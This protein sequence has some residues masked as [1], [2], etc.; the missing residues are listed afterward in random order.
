MGREGSQVLKPKLQSINDDQ[1]VT[2][3]SKQMT[4]TKL[5]E[6]PWLIDP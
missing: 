2:L 4:T 5:A 6:L 1:K 3:K